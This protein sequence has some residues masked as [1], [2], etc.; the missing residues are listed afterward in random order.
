M[1]TLRHA[2]TLG[3]QAAGS[4]ASL[5]ASVTVAARFGLAAQGEFALL[6]SWIDALATIFAVGLPQGLLHL[7]YRTEHAEA[8]LWRWVNRYLLGLLALSLAVFFLLT[9][10]APSGAGDRPR[11]FA[12]AALALPAAVAH[13]LWRS[14]ALRRRG[15]V[16]FAAVTAAPALALL[17]LVAAWAVVGTARG[18]SWM[19]LTAWWCAAAGAAFVVRPPRGAL[20]PQRLAVRELWSVSLQAAMQT[21]AAALLPAVLLSLARW[22][23]GSVAVAGE[24]SLCL[25]VY[26][27]F[28]VAA[29]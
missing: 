23:S 3:L 28:A 20:P 16:V 4:G 7:L 29:A 15:V 1:K 14:L 19:I 12:V 24:L 18:F 2:L 10:P 21:G 17:A 9:L 27:L 6:K 26:L 25:Q 8:T 5:L 22:L 13:Q 11:L